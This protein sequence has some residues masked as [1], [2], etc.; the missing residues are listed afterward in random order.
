MLDGV[1]AINNKGGIMSRYERRLAVDRYIRC[2]GN[3]PLSAYERRLKI[4][5]QTPSGQYD[6]WMTC[7]EYI[8]KMEEEKEKKLVL[9][10]TYENKK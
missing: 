10:R 8:K 7:E 3:V 1:G 2:G 5:A 9:R 4:E 6:N